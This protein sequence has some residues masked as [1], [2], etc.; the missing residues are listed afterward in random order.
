[1]KQA[2]ASSYTPILHNLDG[3]LPDLEGLYK[4]V[5]SHPELRC[6]RYVRQVLQQIACVR[7]VMT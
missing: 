3:L 1:M 6:R 4:D 2:H 7:A 5:H